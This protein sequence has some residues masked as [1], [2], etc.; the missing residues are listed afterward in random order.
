MGKKIL[1]LEKIKNLNKNIFYK[2]LKNNILFIL[3]IK[4]FKINVVK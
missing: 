4:K 3:D 2:T 1:F